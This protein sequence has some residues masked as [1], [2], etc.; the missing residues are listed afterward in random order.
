MDDNYNDITKDEDFD[1]SNELK[2]RFA[3]AGIKI[4]TQ[5]E[6]DQILKDRAAQI[7]YPVK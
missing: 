5:K 7:G 6:I 3:E 4:Y 2:K 1:D